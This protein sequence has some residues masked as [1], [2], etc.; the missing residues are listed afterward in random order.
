MGTSFE[1][2]LKN[3]KQ[4][5]VISNLKKR[6]TV[7]ILGKDVSLFKAIIENNNMYYIS[8]EDY[9]EKLLEVEYDARAFYF[10]YP[11][12]IYALHPD[13]KK[14]KMF[15]SSVGCNMCINN[16]RYNKYV[17]T[18]KKIYKELGEILCGTIVE[19]VITKSKEESNM[20]N[21]NSSTPITVSQEDKTNENKDELF[22][23]FALFEENNLPKDINIK[24]DTNKNCASIEKD[25]SENTILSVMFEP[26]E[27]YLTN[28]ENEKKNFEEEN[29]ALKEQITNMKTYSYSIDS[30]KSNA[31][32][33]FIN[34]CEC[35]IKPFENVYILDT[36]TLILDKARQEYIG[37][38]G[39]KNDFLY[40]FNAAAKKDTIYKDQ[41]CEYPN[42]PFVRI[43]MRLYGAEVLN[44]GLNSKYREYILHQFKN[45]F[46]I[47]ITSNPVILMLITA[48]LNRKVNLD[49]DSSTGHMK[50]SITFNIPHLTM[51]VNNNENN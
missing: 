10:D 12:V 38:G 30:N 47:N 6:D 18:K 5:E 3:I 29:K 35:S 19:D 14:L 42:E 23:N 41:P 9:C 39:G 8:V 34:A 50:T 15:I 33:D 21:E 51:G 26:I 44:F 27:K 43:A 45:M 46:N 22:E 40:D 28:L 48:L 2:R 4:T 1:Q 17:E 24:E 32:I 49:F 36:L 7:N 31:L 13:S 11:S 25:S 16:S 37:N 20:S